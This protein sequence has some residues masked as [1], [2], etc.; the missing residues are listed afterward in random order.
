MIPYGLNYNPLYISRPTFVCM[1]IC[2][3]KHPHIIAH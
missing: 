2:L 3:P 1:C